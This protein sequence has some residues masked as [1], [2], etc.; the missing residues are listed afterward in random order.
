M[1]HEAL[2]RLRSW[3]AALSSDRAPGS[4]EQS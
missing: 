2:E 4:Q 3:E 1:S